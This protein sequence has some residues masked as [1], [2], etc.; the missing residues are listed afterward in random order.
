VDVDATILSSRVIARGTTELALAVP[1]NAAPRPGQFLHIR[2]PGE[3][4]R[5]PISA[6]GYDEETGAARIIVRD[7]GRGSRAISGL[8]A[9][10]RVRLLTPLGR[11]FPMESIIRDIASGKK[12]WLAGGG[13]GA[14]PLLF[15]ASSVR[16]ADLA[17]DS[18]VGFRDEESVIGVREL[19]ECGSVS[20]SVGGLVTDAMTRA[21]E[22]AVP[23][24]ILACGPVPM[25][26]AIQKI[27]AGRGIRGF[28]SVE[29][30]MGC[31]VGACLVC[32]CRTGTGD[33]WE[34]RRVCR[35]GPVF[36]I[37]EVA[38]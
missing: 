10:D 1:R 7:A 35:D 31:G 4:L 18:F 12:I 16:A 21:M 22:S 23:D 11:G 15:A 25:L 38:L 6:S 13:I 19:G 29:E 24:S 17:I 2:A 5:R 9:G 3:F 26:R 32:V 20:V 37:S 27:C 14:A 30:R 8:G 34:H 36:G 33:G 28:M